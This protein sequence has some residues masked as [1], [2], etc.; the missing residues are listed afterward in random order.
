MVVLG[1]HI[2][3]IPDNE[4]TFH[5]QGCVLTQKEARITEGCVRSIE[6]L[7]VILCV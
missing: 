3:D 1:V 7:N 5:T 2:G 4:S 6:Y